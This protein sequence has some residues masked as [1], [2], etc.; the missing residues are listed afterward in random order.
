M[1]TIEPFAATVIQ[2]VPPLAGNRINR[3]LGRSLTQIDAGTSVQLAR[4][5]STT[6][7]QAAKAD[8]V[9]SIARKA[10]QDVA[11][12]CQMQAQL[13]SVLPHACDRLAAIT[14]RAITAMNEVIV[15]TARHL[16]R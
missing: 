7:V 11:L 10:M 9:T 4:I 5:N 16:G 6:E 2:P 3:Q 1:S 13:S 14:D 15:D 8:A 12:I